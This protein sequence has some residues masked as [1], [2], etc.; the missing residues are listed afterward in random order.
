MRAECK[1]KAILPGSES[2]WARWRLA[3]F[4]PDG[5]PAYE[6]GESRDGAEQCRSLAGKRHRT[7]AAKNA[8]FVLAEKSVADLP[9]VC[10]KRACMLP[11]RAVRHMERIVSKRNPDAVS[12]VSPQ[13][14]GENRIKGRSGGSDILGKTDRKRYL[15]GFIWSHARMFQT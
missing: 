3:A 6:L 9:S 8:L 7:R 1:K 13:S 14:L 5:I 15:G 10:Q 2:G 4:E 12:S 11:I